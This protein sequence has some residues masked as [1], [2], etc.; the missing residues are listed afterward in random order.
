[1][2]IGLND[3]CAFGDIT[4]GETDALDVE[5]Y[6]TEMDGWE[7]VDST[8]Q[9]IQRGQGDGG[10]ATPAF[11]V[12]RVFTVTGAIVAGSRSVLV[13]ARHRLNA[14]ASIQP[15]PLTATIGGQALSLMAQRMSGVALRNETDVSVEFSATFLAP[16]GRRCGAALTG[17]T[18]L[19][20]STGGLT[21]PFTVP[22]TLPATVVT[23]QVS[24][25]NPGNTSGKVLMRIDGPCTGP[26]I[27]HVAT[28]S[29]LVFATSLAINAGE[30][31]DIDMDAHTILANGQ[32]SRAGYVTTRGWSQF[33]PGGNTWAFTASTFNA[34]SKLTVTAYPSWL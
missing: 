6:W 26:V 14:A 11:Q 27:T 12:P 32:S 2:L 25:T 33:D 20:Q 34:A 17:S 28:G 30:W 3:T 24:L 9:A 4:L 10:F 5:W 18:F 22:F 15:Q 1:M 29:Q 16:D 7:A 21:I 19:P 8:A 13:D 23:G 31:L